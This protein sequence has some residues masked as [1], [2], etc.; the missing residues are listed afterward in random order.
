[1]RRTLILIS[2]AVLVLGITACSG[3]GDS[4]TG[5]ASGAEGSVTVFSSDAAE[6][7]VTVTAQTTTDR[8]EPSAI[9]TA[10]MGSEEGRT[11]DE[12]QNDEPAPS[13]GVN[14]ASPV[15][16]D[17]ISDVPAPSLEGLT[18][19]YFGES[20]Y[21]PCAALSFA[22]LVQSETGNSQFQTQLMLFHNGEYIGVG[23]DHV[24]QHQVIGSSEDSVSV[25]YKDWE[26]LAAAGAGNAE[27]PNY[28][29]D[30]TYRWTGDGV[31]PEG[32]IPN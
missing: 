5:E 24:L 23:S 10:A 14:S 21:D 17:H 7:T 15:I 20:N 30:V 31:V 9:Q 8:A 28:T 4:G 3:E 27:S 19:S 29:S 32:R 6:T 2:G 25:R 22:S 11:S 13:C 12:E 16:T 26:A 1:M 18:W